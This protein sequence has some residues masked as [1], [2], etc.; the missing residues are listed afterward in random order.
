MAGQRQNG[1]MTDANAS[2]RLDRYFK[3]YASFHRTPGNQRTHFVGIP[4]IVLSTLGLFATLQ[5]GPSNLLGSPLLRV[6]AGVLLWVIG[7]LWYAALDWKLAL[8]FGILMLGFY[9]MGRALPL[10]TL[11]GLFIGGW[12]IQYIGHIR[13]EKQSPAFYKNLLHLMIGPLWIFSKVVGYKR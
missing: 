4:M 7:V 2:S 12:I 5:F 11:W 9:F 3:D 1:V 8:P 6:D 13:Y 10:P